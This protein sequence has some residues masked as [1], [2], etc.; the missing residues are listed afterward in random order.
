MASGHSEE[1][2]LIAR[3]ASF[4]LV[5][6]TAD[7]LSGAVFVT[8]LLERGAE[9]W[10]L[11]LMLGSANLVGL[12]VEAPSGALG[13]RY[14]H[15]RLLVSGLFLWGTGFM[16]FGYADRLAST[17]AG[18]YLWAFGF[19]LHS[20]TLTALVVNRI[21][22]RDRS[23]RIART[24]WFGQVSGHSGAVLGA[25]SVMVAG[26]WLPA[27]ALI[28]AGGVV[29]VAL[30]ALAHVCFPRSP[31]QPGRRLGE[32]VRE[33]AVS[34]VGRRFLPL[35]ALT[36]SLTSGIAL[37]VVS[38]QP[39]LLAVHGE[40]VRRNGLMLLMMMSALVAGSACSRFVGRDRPHVWAPLFAAAVGLP[41]ALAAHGLVPLTAGL[42]ASEFLLGLT[43][44]L[45][46]VWQQLMFSDANRNT[47]FSM[48]GMVS[49]LVRALTVVSFGWLWGLLGMAWSV[50]SM[51]S[52][53]VVAA[54]VSAVSSR[55]LPESTR[56]AAHPSD[57][58][59]NDGDHSSGESEPD[60]NAV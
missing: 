14:G 38:W 15:R 19:H 4:S 26:T 18:M 49:G 42:L 11:G 59:K 29:L 31:G 57:E 7:F 39:M 24:M 30:A 54:V 9:P 12:V 1:S 40:D 60:E 41:L 43:G 28:S 33:S 17:L 32:I 6:A 20:G 51:I 52:V 53:G 23:T 46:G 55:L 36:A 45:S 3:Y 2:S 8:V 58:S 50:T 25:A 13:D 22:S 37:L 27:D 44:V 21:G 35:V 47:M 5:G 34:M 48:L 56:F 16:L 10:V